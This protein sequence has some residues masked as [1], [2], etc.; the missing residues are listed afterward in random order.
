[1][2]LKKRRKV[3]Q[4]DFKEVAER[5][6]ILEVRVGSHLFG[7]NTPDSDLD[8][9]GI[10]MP[11]DELLYG[12]HVCKEVDLSEQVKDEAGRN[13]KDAVDRKLHE[14]RKFVRLAMENNPNILHVLFADERNIVF[15]DKFGSRLL[16]MAER[17]PHKGAHRRFIGYAHSQKHKMRIRP[18][19]YLALEHGLKVLG[20]FSD[21]DVLADVIGRTRP[22]VGFVDS[23]KGKH[24]KCGDL[25]FERGVFVKRAKRQ[26]KERL[27]KATSR[28]ALYTKYGYDVKHSSNL[29]QLLMEGIELMETGAIQMPLKYAQ[30][31]LDVKNGKYTVEEIMEWSDD[32][33]EDARRAF[34]KSELPV[35]PRV[36]E[37]ES[38]V[39][40][41]VK[42][43]KR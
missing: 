10:F 43:Y 23:G 14:Y 1:V 33:E 15:K 26:I 39:I 34:E 16:S 27:S 41:E 3:S 36:K 7:T 37:I 28:A 2:T 19:N 9:C 20:D 42:R 32:L 17:F 30:D 4:V 6:K 21:N 13:T 38:F 12:F 18:E 35:N 24:V 29:V 11:S 31:V 25:S 8:L 40:Q 5:N 22:G